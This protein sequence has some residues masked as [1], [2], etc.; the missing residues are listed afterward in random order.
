MLLGLLALLVASATFSSCSGSGIDWDAVSARTSD[1]R[2]QLYGMDAKDRIPND[3]TVRLWP[4]Y[5]HEAHYQRIGRNASDL[6]G[7]E[8]LSWGYGAHLTDA[9]LELVRRDPGVRWVEA[10]H[11]IYG[12]EPVNSSVVEHSVSA[13]RMSQLSKREYG[14]VQENN[15]PYGLRMLAAP[16]KISQLPVLDN[17]VYDFVQGAGRGVNV[18]VL[19]SGIYLG[20]QYFEGRATNFKGLSS[21]ELSPYCEET[22]D[23]RTGHGTQ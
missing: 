11:H 21:D 20:H 6:P 19:D 23:D 10:E 17:G 16:K 5:S 2:A 14:L 9:L 7:F 12:M 3:Y 4:D 15:A 18:Y 1:G 13:A 8:W 22:M